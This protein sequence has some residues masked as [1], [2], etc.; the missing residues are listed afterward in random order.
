MDATDLRTRGDATREQ[1]AELREL[2]QAKVYTLE[3]RNQLYADVEAA[4]GLSQ[5][6]AS[7]VLTWLRVQ[8][9][10]DGSP[11]RATD[12]QVQEIEKLLRERIRPAPWAKLIRS[13]ITA[14]TM[15]HVEADRYLRDLRGMP[16][17]VFT[18]PTGQ[19]I[20]GDTPLGYFALTHDDDQVRCYRIHVDGHGALIVEQFNGPKPGQRYKLRDHKATTVAKAIAADPAAAGRLFATTR[21]RCCDCN[22]RLDREDQPGFPHGLGED[23]WNNRQAAATATANDPERNETHA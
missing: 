12:E 9:N 13:R 8:P 7:S 16:K 10:L 19:R 4:K 17:K 6:R 18:A 2:L 5:A 23:C 3:W 14:R 1:R 11:V 21:K 20:L 15:T 22:Q